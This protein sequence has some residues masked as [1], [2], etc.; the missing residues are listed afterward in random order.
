MC[1]TSLVNLKLQ[2][3][4]YRSVEVEKRLYGPSFISNGYV[5]IFVLAY[6]FNITYIDILLIK[7]TIH[8][9]RLC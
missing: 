1:V 7:R 4:I 8:L 9:I 5:Y 2:Y 3:S 6:G